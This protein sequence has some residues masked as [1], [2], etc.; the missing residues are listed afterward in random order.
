ML[1]FAQAWSA[2]NEAHA[3]EDYFDGVPANTVRTTSPLKSMT[4]EQWKAL[5]EMWSSPKHKAKEGG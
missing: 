5:V 2:A 3:Q 4:D 1:R